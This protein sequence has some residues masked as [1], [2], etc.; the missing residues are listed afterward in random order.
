LA[1]PALDSLLKDGD[2]LLDP[3]KAKLSQSSYDP[4]GFLS[5]DSVGRGKADCHLTTIHQPGFDLCQLTWNLD[6][7]VAMPIEQAFML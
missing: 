6:D 1:D 3:A 7:A 5:Q 4:Q 2:G